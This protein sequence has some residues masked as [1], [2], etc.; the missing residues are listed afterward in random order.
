M[1]L[2]RVS[3]LHKVLIALLATFF[4]QHAQ[5]QVTIDPSSPHLSDPNNP[6]S[7]LA[8][9]FY[10][11]PPTGTSG[12]NPTV[13]A[14]QFYRNGVA[15][16]G[17]AGTGTVS[18]SPGDTSESTIDYSDLAGNIYVVITQTTYPNGSA[19]SNTY[20]SYQ[21]GPLVG[22]I[23]SIRLLTIVFILLIGVGGIMLARQ[24]QESASR[25]SK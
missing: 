23:S 16:Q 7:P 6:H 14:Y 1:K 4:I 5:A 20:N 12:P 9:D 18:K 3:N 22:S 10:F 19:T 21:G 8:V 2:S 24:K 13:A 15:V 11:P 17:S 25:S